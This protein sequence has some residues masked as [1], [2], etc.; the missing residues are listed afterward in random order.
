MFVQSVNLTVW[1]ESIR[2]H[3]KKTQ[4]WNVHEWRRAN[5]VFAFCLDTPLVF[6]GEILQLVLY[7]CY[8][9][10]FL[11]VSLTPPHSSTPPPHFSIRDGMEVEHDNEAFFYFCWPNR[12]SGLLNTGWENKAEKQ[13]SWWLLGDGSDTLF[14]SVWYKTEVPYCSFSACPSIFHYI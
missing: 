4:L 13:A 8:R 7:L 9:S 3:K 11:P 5:L 1:S 10:R 14:S 6:A 12:N 2:L